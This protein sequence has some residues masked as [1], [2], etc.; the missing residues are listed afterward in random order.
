MLE[1]AALVVE[2]VTELVDWLVGSVVGEVDR[3]F[4]CETLEVDEEVEV[5]ME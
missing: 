3:L 2:D 1:L 5:A 4:V